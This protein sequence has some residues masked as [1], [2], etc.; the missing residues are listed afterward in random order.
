MQDTE[1]LEATSSEPLSYEEEIRMQQE[2]R[3]DEKKCT[4]IILAR[5]LLSLETDVDG[6]GIDDDVVVDIPPPPS[7]CDSAKEE[8]EDTELNDC[9]AN[10]KPSYPTLIETTLDSMIGDI[11]LFLSEE[12]EEDV[13]EDELA[14]NDVRQQT[15]QSTATANQLTSHTSTPQLLSQ[16]E[17]DIMI[18]KPSHRHKNLGTELVLSIM[19]YGALYLGIKRYFVKINEKNTSSLHLFKDK[20]EFEECAYVKCFGEYELECKFDTSNDM[21]QWVEKKW[22]YHWNNSRRNAEGTKDGEEEESDQSSTPR[23]RLYD[24][25]KCP[26]E[27]QT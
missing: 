14:D 9:N 16:A 21:I 18:A 3:D 1:L 24:V 27:S 6:E 15:V 2:W 5:D 11:T 12:E 22:H 25:Y 10:N 19:H 8:V 23:R 7:L 26:L 20:L 17:L 4:F 13:D